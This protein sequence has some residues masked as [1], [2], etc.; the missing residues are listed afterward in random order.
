VDAPAA[1]VAVPAM[2][3]EGMVDVR[4]FA[5]LDKAGEV[6]EETRASRIWATLFNKYGSPVAGMTHIGSIERL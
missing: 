2:A 4:R 1:P 6:E 3:V 5:Y